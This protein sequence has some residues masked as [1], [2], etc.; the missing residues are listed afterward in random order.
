MVVEKVDWLV[1]L[2]VALLVVYRIIYQVRM[3]K[4]T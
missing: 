3:R 2:M 1:L 4:V